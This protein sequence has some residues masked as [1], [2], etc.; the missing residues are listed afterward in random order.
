LY[1][2]GSWGLIAQDTQSITTSRKLAVIPFSEGRLALPYDTKPDSVILHNV[3][4]Q[5]VYEDWQWENKQLVLRISRAQLDT[6]AGFYI[7]Y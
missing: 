3:S 7:V 4:G 6:V 2:S 1:W 5:Y